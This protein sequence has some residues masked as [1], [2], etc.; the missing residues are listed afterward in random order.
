MQIPINAAVEPIT[1]PGCENEA[2]TTY[3]INR[4]SRRI[5]IW[6]V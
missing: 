5:A 6:L 2:G 1:C 3:L 4:Y